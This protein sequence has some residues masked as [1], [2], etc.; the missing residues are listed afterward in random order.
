MATPKP[1]AVS[2]ALSHCRTCRIRPLSICAPLD[3][4]ETARLAAII[5]TLEA[6]PKDEL[7][8]E[9]QAAA[10]TYNVTA[11][12]LKL[13]KSLPDGRRQITGFLFPGDFI[14]LGPHGHYAQSAEAVTHV[15]LCRFPRREFDRLL[16][17]FPKLEH[18]L[19]EYA[20]TELSAAQEQIL[21]LGRKTAVE[22]LASFLLMLE[23]RAMRRGLPGNPIA[24]PMGR[25]DIADYLGLT[26]ETVSRLFTRLK[27]AQ[28]VR[29]LE[30]NF[31]QVLDQAGLEDLAEG[32]SSLGGGR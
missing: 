18:R 8:H 19:L 20:E 22:R 13:F 5:T 29:L 4:D 2:D 14:G 15:K 9:G 11:G 30:G 12:T 26:I 25:T 10:Y 6:A 17:D 31:V 16:G 21:L 32:A 27:T 23:K 28:V 7:F 24:V 3:A 1:V